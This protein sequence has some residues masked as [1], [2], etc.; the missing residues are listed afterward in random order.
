MGFIGNALNL[1]V[2]L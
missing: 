2:E 1:R